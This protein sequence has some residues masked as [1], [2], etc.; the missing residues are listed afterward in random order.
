VAMSSKQIKIWERDDCDLFEGPG[1]EL[2]WGN[3]GKA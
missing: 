1:P 2:D 3:T